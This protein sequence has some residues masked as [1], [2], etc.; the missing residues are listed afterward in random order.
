MMSLRSRPTLAAGLAATVPVTLAPRASPRLSASASCLVRLL[1]WA[2]SQPW[3]APASTGDLA[4]VTVVVVEP[5]RS[6]IFAMAWRAMFV[7]EKIIDRA[8]MAPT[9]QPSLLLPGVAVRL[10][11]ADPRRKRWKPQATWLKKRAS[12]S[13]KMSR[14]ARAALI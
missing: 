2:P 7:N 10:L 3:G 5:R 9:N 8:T 11:L 13:R 14:A 1:S 6:L 4:A 12:R